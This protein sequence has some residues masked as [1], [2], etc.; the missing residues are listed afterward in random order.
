MRTAYVAFA[1]VMLLNVAYQ[2]VTAGMNVFDG[3]S[4]DPHGIG[5]SIAHLW[6]LGM[7]I[8]AA[9]GKLGRDLIA[10]GAVLL[11]L[12]VAQFPIQDSGAIGFLHPLLGLI[13]AFGAYAAFQR[14]RVAPM[15]ASGE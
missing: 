2:F 10:M 15:P 7:V 13:I 14:A 3:D 8:T 9:A 6:P 11:L 12:V 5:A 4:I 1:A